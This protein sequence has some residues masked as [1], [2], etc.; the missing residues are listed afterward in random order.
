MSRLFDAEDGGKTRATRPW[1]RS[2]E[3][4]RFCDVTTGTEVRIKE[5]LCGENGESLSLFS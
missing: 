4:G 3:M 1:E 5:V 2:W